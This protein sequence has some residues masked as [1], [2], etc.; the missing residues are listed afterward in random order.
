MVFLNNGKIMYNDI[1]EMYYY[2]FNEIGLA[3]NNQNQYLIDSDTGVPIKY[4]DKFIKVSVN[5]QPVY[6][7]KNDVIFEPQT[8][9]NIVVCLLGYYLDK[10]ANRIRF[11]GQGV[12]ESPDKEKQRLVIR[13]NMGDIMSDFYKNI[14][15]CF[16]DS[17]FKLADSDS[18]L[19]NFDI[20][21]EK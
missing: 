4:K 15:L 6:A 18:D 2:L 13:T 16:I 3:V 1:Y 14:Y 8:N 9:Y 12:E 10:E 11:I 19:S 20:V 5:G 21:E 17:I 7:G